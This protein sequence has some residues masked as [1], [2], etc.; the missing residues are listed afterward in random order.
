MKAPVVVAASAYGADY[1]RRVGHAQLV[2]VVAAAGAAGLEI[3]RELCDA[4]PDFRQLRDVLLA[5]HLFSVYSASIE[6]FRPDG[7]LAREE[8]EQ[9]VAEAQL[10]ESRFVKLSLG[11]FSPASDMRE[12]S[13]FVAQTPLPLLIENDQTAHGGMLNA[14]A[15]FL[16]V[17]AGTGVSVGMTF[18]IGNWRW[19]GVDAEVAARTL[20]QHV[21]YVHC[22]GVYEDGGKLMAAPLEHDDVHWRQLFSYFR[23]GVHRAIEFPLT[24]PDLTEVTRHYVAMLASA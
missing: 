11:H 16:A 18:D 23:R 7:T 15:S 3:H 2:P 12:W 19:H 10:L 5:H 21:Q 20:A 14:I 9:V 8:L 4:W 6:L 22:K 24:G 17:C 1:V 13:R